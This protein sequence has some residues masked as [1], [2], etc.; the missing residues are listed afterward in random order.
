MDDCWCGTVTAETL[1]RWAP[2]LLSPVCLI[3]RVVLR[4]IRSTT[5][6]V[7]RTYFYGNGVV[8]WCN[9]KK[10]FELNI[11]K[12]AWPQLA[13]NLV[14]FSCDDDIQALQDPSHQRLTCVKVSPSGRYMVLGGDEQTIKVMACFPKQQ[15]NGKERYRDQ[16][17]ASWRLQQHLWRT[18]ATAMSEYYKNQ[19]DATKRKTFSTKLVLK[20]QRSV[21]NYGC[22]T[23]RYRD[24]SFCQG[25]YIL[26]LPYS[27]CDT[28]VPWSLHFVYLQ[29]HAD[30]DITS[31]ACS[32]VQS[33]VQSSKSSDV[34]YF[35]AQAV[36]FCLGIYARLHW[37]AGAWLGE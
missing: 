2:P 22:F 17:T 13:L 18:D 35:V 19:T 33:K 29:H 7:Y 37:T 14:C 15:A 1:F 4:D 9:L 21:P 26:W 5:R 12:H 24:V 6:R 25:H 11:Y 32:A 8:S 16:E 34:K 28:L 36:I 31:T 30:R 20:S 27:R 10:L 3:P 23:N